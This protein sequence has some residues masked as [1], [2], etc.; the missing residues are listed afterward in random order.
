MGAAA[1]PSLFP[2]DV[3]HHSVLAPLAGCVCLPAY[4][5]RPAHVLLDA[6]L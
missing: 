5:E 2:D 3:I 6:W 1:F 4:W